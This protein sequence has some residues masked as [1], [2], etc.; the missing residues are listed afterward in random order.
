MAVVYTDKP[1]SLI[2]TPHNRTGK[3][4]DFTIDASHMAVVHNVLIRSYNSIYQQAPHIQPVDYADFVGY[5]LAW[6]EMVQGHHD[7]EEAVL[8][9]GI[10]EVTGVKGI[11]DGEKAEHAALYAGLSSLATYLGTCRAQPKTFNASALLSIMDA[12][13]PAFATHLAN[14]P[15][16]LASLSTYAFDIKALSAKTAE[17]SMARTSTFNLLPMLWYNLDVEFEGGKWRDFPPV[18]APMRWVLVN[19]LGRWQARWWRFGTCGADGKRIEL[20]ALREG[21]PA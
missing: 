17:Y 13:A 19:I 1:L 10:E 9:P 20:L 11:M 16:A 6:H 21:Y 2:Q 14:E 4:D 3:T 15:P 7:S 12:F 18:P 8:F 5:C